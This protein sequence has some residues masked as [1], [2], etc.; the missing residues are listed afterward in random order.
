MAQ[1]YDLLVV[2]QDKDGKSWWTKIGA[3]FEN[4]NS[5][6]FS[7]TFEALPIPNKDG[8]VRVIMKQPTDR[9]DREPRR[10]RE[11]TR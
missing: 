6:G 11:A 5:D 9:E 10:E 1:R 2:R 7:L 3:A 4:R 8:E